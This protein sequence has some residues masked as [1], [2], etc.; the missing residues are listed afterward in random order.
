M[1]G[2]VATEAAYRHGEPWL[3]AV[4]QYIDANLDRLDAYLKQHI[5]QLELLRPEGT[6][7]AWIDCRKL[8]LSP[9]ELGALFFDQAKLYL[10][11]GQI[12]G[13]EGE[14][15]MRINVACPRG[16]LN[17]ALTRLQRAVAAL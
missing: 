16:R 3:D 7:L 2:I 1:L 12:F 8:G 13:T 4:I 5:P 6:Y 14:G 9:E 17:K 15:F 10:D 11:E